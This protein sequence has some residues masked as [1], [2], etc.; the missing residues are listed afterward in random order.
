MRSILHSL[1]KSE[2]C[3]TE[4]RGCGR[5]YRTSGSWVLKLTSCGTTS[6]NSCRNWTKTGLPAIVYH[7]TDGVN[8]DRDATEALLKSCADVGVPIYFNCVGV[9]RAKF[10]FL[11]KIADD[12]PNV[13]FTAITDLARTASSDD[14]Y[15]HLL[16]TELLEWLKA[17][18][19]A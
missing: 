18:A 16:P 3:R 7:F 14:I 12:L 8:D 17:C 9:G 4:L 2:R 1:T 10:D 13:E 19:T 6:A 15:N 5:T 11:Q